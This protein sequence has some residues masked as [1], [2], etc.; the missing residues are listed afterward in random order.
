VLAPFFVGQKNAFES[1]KPLFFRTPAMGP[2]R[3]PDFIGDFYAELSI[4][5]GISAR[6]ATGL[7]IRHI[8]HMCCYLNG[9]LTVQANQDHEKHIFDP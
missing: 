5:T 9:Q 3:A 8:W 6:S 2:S 1:R 7:K 4:N